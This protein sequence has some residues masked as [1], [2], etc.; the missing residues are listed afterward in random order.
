MK[1]LMNLLLLMPVLLINAQTRGT[2]STENVC[3][4]AVLGRDI[5][6]SI[7]FPPGYGVDKTTYPVLYL[8]HGYGD[9][10]TG[11][12]RYG[13]MQRITTEAIERGDILPVI[14]V[15]PD[16][17]KSWYVNDYKGAVRF[18]D[19]FFTD[20]V[21]F[22][23]KTY[24]IAG[25]KEFRA[26]AGLSM[27]GYGSLLYALKHPDMFVACTPMSAAIFT[28]DEFSVMTKERK[29]LFGD[30]FGE[31]KEGQ[32]P[33]YWKSYSV[34]NIISNYPEADKKKVKFYIDCGDDDFLYKG[35]DA[36]HTILREKAIPHEF[37]IRDGAHTWSYWRASLRDAL[38]FIGDAF[39]H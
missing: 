22:I 31:M 30:L 26:I 19:A 7:Y 2:I 11:W 33:E 17:G 29:S 8:L 4:S 1:R 21:P 12:I 35:N 18:E 16:A 6:Y 32:L 24:P 13:D 23:E 5:K 10:Q 3:K 38:K 36:L 9:D 28:D 15:M 34:L 20:F 25:T 27:G 14:V 37:R 39:H